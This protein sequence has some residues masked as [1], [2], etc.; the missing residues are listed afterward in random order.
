[1]KHLAKAFA[2]ILVLVGAT[3]AAQPHPQHAGPAITTDKRSYEPGETVGF[4]GTNWAPGEAVRIVISG[5]P[6]SPWETLLATADDAGSFRV[7]AEMPEAPEMPERRREV[8]GEGEGEDEEGAITYR[9]VATGLLP[10]RTADTEFEEGRQDSDGERLIDSELHWTLRQSYPTFE[11]KP[12]WIREASM[13][14]AGIQR[15]TPIGHNVKTSPDRLKANPLALSNTGFTALGPQ[16]ERMTGCSGCFD[17]GQTSGRVND[18]RID[19]TTT[20][21]GSIVA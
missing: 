13:Q 3:L 14:D 2:A 5:P 16:P 10:S 6:G 15:R 4:V 11:F 8:A 21:Q 20:V 18:I 9:A 7:T 1:M 12:R 17:Y 19:P